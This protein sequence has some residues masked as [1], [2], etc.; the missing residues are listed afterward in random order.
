VIIPLTEA[1][2][3]DA[4]KTRHRRLAL[5]ITIKSLSCRLRPELSRRRDNLTFSHHAEV[6]ALP[7]VE[8]DALLG[9][10]AECRRDIDQQYSAENKRHRNKDRQIRKRPGLACGRV[11]CDGNADKSRLEAERA[12]F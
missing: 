7:P 8:A 1:L 10:Y 11:R 5:S 3:N 9:L 4:R 12:C 6:A 2:R